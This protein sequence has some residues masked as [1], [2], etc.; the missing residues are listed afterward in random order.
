MGESEIINKEIN[1][2]N[3]EQLLEIIKKE[4]NEINDEQLLE[5]INKLRQSNPDQYKYFLNIQTFANTCHP[6]KNYYE[7]MEVLLGE[8]R[9]IVSNEREDQCSRT[10]EIYLLPLT[11]PVVVH[12]YGR[13]GEP[14]D[15]FDVLYVFTFEKGWQ[16][17]Y[18]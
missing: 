1:E 11:S 13:G 12:F 3:D 10:S 17:V 6:V 2:I 15:K 4:I 16:Q 18:I 5:I 9:E 8:V 7:S 14:Q